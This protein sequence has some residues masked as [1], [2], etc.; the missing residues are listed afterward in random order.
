MTARERVNDQVINRILLSPE[1]RRAVSHLPPAPPSQ[2]KPS[3]EE[4]INRRFTIAKLIILESVGL[5][6]FLWLVIEGVR[7]ELHSV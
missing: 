5:I 1:D 4:T 6:V 3:L 7:H 2:A